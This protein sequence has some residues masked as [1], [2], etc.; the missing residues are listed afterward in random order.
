M[1][2]KPILCLCVVAILI[3]LFVVTEHHPRF[4]G[5]WRSNPNI[6]PL[7]D[8][9]NATSTDLISFDNS[10]YLKKSGKINLHS[11]I[12]ISARYKTD[13]DGNS[14]T[15]C[16]NLIA[17][18]RIT[19]IWTM[20]DNHDDRLRL[21]FDN[22]SPEIVI[23]PDSITCENP[24]L[25]TGQPLM[26]EFD[27]QNF[28]YRWQSFLL[29][30]ANKYFSRYTYIKVVKADVGEMI[31]QLSGDDTIGDIRSTFISV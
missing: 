7:P 10:G 19:G 9:A 1:V 16:V 21:E 22:D 24:M 2:I 13:Y 28:A 17:T 3:M 29:S 27:K 18:A 23:N 30:E 4:I 8:D 11:H 6:F 5:S 15:C 26:Q 14:I 25:S 12:D 31:C 20:I